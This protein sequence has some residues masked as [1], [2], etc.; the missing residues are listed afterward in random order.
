LKS[1]KHIAILGGGASSL[2]T[3]YF[4]SKEG[5][6]VSIYEKGKALGRKFLVAGRI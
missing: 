1:K 6:K 2:L 5:V 4:L 3:A